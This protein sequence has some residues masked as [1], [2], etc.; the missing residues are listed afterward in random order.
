VRVV[1]ANVLL[2]AVNEDAVHHE[3]SRRWLDEAL[4]GTDAVGF[5]WLVVTA[6][7]RLATNAAI[8]PRPLPIDDALAVVDSWL[9]QPTAAVL[10]PTARHLALL[11][12]L[13][14]P[15]GAGGSLVADA[16]LAAIALEHG[17]EVVSFDN[18]FSRFAGVRWSPP[19]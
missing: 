9:A 17:A 12:G 15:L 14:E 5:T 7:L 8:V 11:G 18:D 1:D 4:S 13:L 19:P 10:E 16:H 2:Y 6:F 3:R